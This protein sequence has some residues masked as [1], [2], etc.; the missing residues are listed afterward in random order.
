MAVEEVG[1]DEGKDGGVC[2]LGKK[3]KALGKGKK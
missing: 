3:L 1:D 2:V